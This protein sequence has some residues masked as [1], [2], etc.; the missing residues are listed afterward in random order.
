ML[1]DIHVHF[2]FLCIRLLDFLVHLVI[3]C[4]VISKA[5]SIS[6]V[7]PV[8]CVITPSL[9]FRIVLLSY[10]LFPEENLL[11]FYRHCYPEIV[12]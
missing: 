10:L 2:L 12:K 6:A 4:L 7:T 5:Y 9:K 1:P 3:A 8:I 11:N